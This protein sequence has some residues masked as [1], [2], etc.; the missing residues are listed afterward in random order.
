MHLTHRPV[1]NTS[2]V[3]TLDVSDIAA[4][5]SPGQAQFHSLFKANHAIR[6]F[7]RR[8][9]VFLTDKCGPSMSDWHKGNAVLCGLK[10]T[11]VYKDILAIHAET[12]VTYFLK[13]M[14]T[15]HSA[16]GRSYQKITK[17]AKPATAVLTGSVQHFDETEGTEFFF[18]YAFCFDD[19]TA[20]EHQK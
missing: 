7:E 9:W 5:M 19:T 18:Q 3:W 8:L 16:A 17:V 4:P 2:Q 15:V 10:Q 1:V 6:C 14:R 12:K 11:D 13:E 20:E